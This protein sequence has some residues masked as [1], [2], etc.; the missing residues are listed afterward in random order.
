MLVG[1]VA[2]TIE[3]LARIL[4]SEFTKNTELVI[5]KE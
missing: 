5:L 4:I 3:V 1:G 2:N